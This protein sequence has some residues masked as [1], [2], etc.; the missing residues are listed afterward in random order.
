MRVKAF[1]EWRTLNVPKITLSSHLGKFYT[2]YFYTIINW[3][4]KSP[5][6]EKR[7]GAFLY[8]KPFHPTL[9]ETIMKMSNR[10]SLTGKL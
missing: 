8:F 10:L 6:N 9:G 2:E 5:D 7:S 1:N 3:Q 4:Q